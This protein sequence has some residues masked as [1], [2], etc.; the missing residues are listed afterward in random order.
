MKRRK[1]MCCLSRG[2]EKC[3]IPGKNFLRRSRY[4][5]LRIG[6]IH[7]VADETIFSHIRKALRTVERLKMHVE[8][9]KA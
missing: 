5:E 7:A 6:R 4:Q 1:S 2:F 3:F 9:M 8:G